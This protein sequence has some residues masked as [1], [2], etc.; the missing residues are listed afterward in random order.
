LQPEGESVAELE[1]AVRL[2]LFL[3]WNSVGE[4]STGRGFLEPILAGS[5]AGS[6]LDRMKAHHQQRM[7][8]RRVR[9][10]YESPE[11][12]QQRREKKRCLRQEK[13]IERLKEKKER[14]RLW[15]EKQ[16]NSS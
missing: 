13:H 15:K 3:V 7:E 1:S 10:E 9:H 14:D 11:R 4:F 12:V 2:I 8:E 16:Q 6:V 5:W